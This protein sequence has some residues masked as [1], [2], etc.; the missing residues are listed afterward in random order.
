MNNKVKYGLKNVYYSVITL[1][2]NVPSYATPVHIPGAVNLGLTPAGEKIK[3]AA[4]HH[5]QQ[6]LPSQ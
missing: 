2:N 6:S 1:A 4:D 3:F 5:N